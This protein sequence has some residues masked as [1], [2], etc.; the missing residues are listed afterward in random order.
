LNYNRL[1]EL[2]EYIYS[3]FPFVYQVAFVQIEPIGFSKDNLADLWIDPYDY[4]DKL[5]EAVMNLHNRN[6]QVTIFNSQLCV[7]PKNLRRFAVQSISD[8][9][10][11]Y[12]DE[13]VNCI[14]KTECAGFF[15]A[16]KDIHSNKIKAIQ[17]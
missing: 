6:L 7:L 12:I 11:I 10:N 5:E 13:C 15:S 2:S 14:L 3:N 9:K 4:N 8:W 1:P 16:S 17:K